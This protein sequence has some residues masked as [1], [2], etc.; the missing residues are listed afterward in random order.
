MGMVMQLYRAVLLS[1]V[2]C[3]AAGLHPR[4]RQDEQPP[5]C[6]ERARVALFLFC[7]RPQESGPKT[8]VGTRAAVVGEPSPTTGS[9]DGGRMS[10]CV[11]VG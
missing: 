6:L 10:R 7:C 3:C 4:Q 8:D 1:A 9:G 2:P 11:V 5:Q